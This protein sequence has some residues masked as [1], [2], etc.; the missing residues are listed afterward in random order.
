MSDPP[1]NLVVSLSTLTKSASRDELGN[2]LKPSNRR[3]V[4]LDVLNIHLDRDVSIATTSDLARAFSAPELQSVT[5]LFLSLLHNLDAFSYEDYRAA[6]RFPTPALNE[7]TGSFLHELRCT[8]RAV[9]ATNTLCLLAAMTSIDMQQREYLYL[10]NACRNRRNAQSAL[11]LS[12]HGA[13]TTLY[14]RCLLQFQSAAPLIAV[15]ELKRGDPP[16][17]LCCG[18]CLPTRRGAALFRHIRVRNCGV[19]VGSDRAHAVH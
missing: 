4:Y 10:T 6:S 9:Y 13:S 12:F 8:N 3:P 15:V 18:V 17:R 14:P 16:R 1:R 5:A 11:G 7:S 19:T 2:G